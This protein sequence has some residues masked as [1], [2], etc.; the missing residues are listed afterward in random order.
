MNDFA[1]HCVNQVLRFTF[2]DNWSQLSEERKTQFAFNLGAVTMFLSLKKEDSF[3]QMVLLQQ[4]KLTTHE[5]REKMKVLFVQYGLKYIPEF[6]EKA[7]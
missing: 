7:F 3:D 6:A 2:C 5:F 4:G 1:Q